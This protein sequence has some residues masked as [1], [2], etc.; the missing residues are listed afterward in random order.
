MEPL[1]L[2]AHRRLGEGLL[3]G[4]V[5]G[6]VEVELGP[7][8][9]GAVAGDE[10]EGRQGAHGLG[11]QVGDGEVVAVGAAGHGD[12][13]EG[14]VGG[15]GEVGGGLD[16][17]PL[18]ADGRGDL[19]AD[20]VGD[21]G[22]QHPRRRQAPLGEAGGGGEGV[23]GGVVGVEEVGEAEAHQ[24]LAVGLALGQGLAGAHG[25]VDVLPLGDQVDV[26]PGE[27][28]D[29]AGL[30]LEDPPLDQ[31]AQE[32]PGRVGPAPA[33]LAAGGEEVA[34][35]PGDE[36]DAEGDEEGR[37]GHDR[38]RL[39][40]IVAMSAPGTKAVRWIPEAAPRGR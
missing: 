2:D 18:G 16:G 31:G 29:E 37:G 25:A 38:H 17:H 39:R 27:E 24:G 35:R 20:Q 36:G 4:A 34:R 21:G 6:L 28:A 32:A 8:P 33:A 3:H 1:A 19:P 26:A 9:V 30:A 15:G 40:P 10:V 12:G 5:E 7:G 23:G 22:E 14:V 13:A 11:H